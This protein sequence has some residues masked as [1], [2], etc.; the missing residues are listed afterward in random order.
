MDN[1]KADL[2]NVMYDIVDGRTA[3]FDISHVLHCGRWYS[4]L[5]G[6]STFFVSVFAGGLQCIKCLFGVN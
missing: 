5:R 1:S 2:I 6:R 4:F 3:D